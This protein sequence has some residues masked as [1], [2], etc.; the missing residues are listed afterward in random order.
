MKRGCQNFEK[1]LLFIHSQVHP[2]HPM[3][4]TKQTLLYQTITNLNWEGV[5]RVSGGG[6]TGKT[7][8]VAKSLETLLK[9]QPNLNIAVSTITHQA[10]ATIK[11][12]IPAHIRPQ[13]TFCTIASL[14]C[15]GMYTKGIGQKATLSAK[16]TRLAKFDL[17]VIDESSMVGYQESKVLL[18][19]KVRIIEMGDFAQLPPVMAKPNAFGTAKAFKEIRLTEQMRNGGEI[20][21]IAEKCREEIFYPQESAGNVLVHENT[22]SLVQGFLRKLRTSDNPT[23]VIYLTF[24]NKRK[25]EVAKLAHKSLYGNEPFV[26]GQFL[27]LEQNLKVESKGHNV[28]VVEVVDEVLV[29]KVPTTILVV[30]G[31]GGQETIN[32]VTTG[33]ENILKKEMENLANLATKTDDAGVLELLQTQYDELDSLVSI[34]SPFVLTIHKSQGMSIPFVFLDTLDISTGKGGFKKNLLYVGVSRASKEL[35]TV[36]VEK[37]GASTAH[38]EYT[39]MRKLVPFWEVREIVFQ[40]YGV[41]SFRY[42]EGK[43]KFVKVAQEFLAQR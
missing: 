24:T 29:G 38:Q 20:Y 12:K 11:G 9:N 41:T 15:K 22:E 32:V 6:G 1:G 14:L 42:T 4:N 30:E 33:Y 21:R 18:D 13:I 27:R 17:V 25:E 8:T 28:T 36:K 26:E 37:K 39:E 16:G 19:S 34:S 3:L 31:A 2:N 40:R 5:L 43:E 23:D 35:N 7:Y 10:L